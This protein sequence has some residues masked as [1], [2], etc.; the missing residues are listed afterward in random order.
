M[1]ELLHRIAVLLMETAPEAPLLEARAIS[2]THGLEYIEAVRFG[3][4]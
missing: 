1:F 3:D 2:K 4:S